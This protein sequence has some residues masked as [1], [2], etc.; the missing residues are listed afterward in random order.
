MSSNR[1]LLFSVLY[2]GLSGTMITDYVDSIRHQTDQGFDWLMINDQCD[3]SEKQLF[4]PS[5]KWIDLDTTLSF[6]KIRELGIA[7]GHEQDYDFIVF[8]DIDDYYGKDRIAASKLHLADN[9]FVF[10][11]LQVVDVQK[12]LIRDNLITRL[13]VEP[14]PSNV[15][16][17]LD[18]NYIGLSHSAVRLD[19][20]RDFVIPATI[21]VVDWWVFSFLLVNGRTGCFLP[22]VDTFYRQSDANY[23]GVFNLLDNARLQRGID[24]KLRH[25]LGLQDYCRQ[26]KLVNLADIFRTKWHEMIELNQALQNA[27][28][29]EQYIER[30]NASMA[31]IYRGWWSEILP[32]KKWEQ[33]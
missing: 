18:Y 30:I 4:P 7:F 11:E 5:V 27:E 8:S 29:A 31:R 24:V 19:A 15:N 26:R 20:L 32:L 1:T 21:D 17:I 12:R 16:F 22:D 2:P 28:F 10:T 13:A 25:Y 9:D 23:V 6:G 33:L 14:H 3:G